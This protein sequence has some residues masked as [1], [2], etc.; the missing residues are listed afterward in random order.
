[1]TTLFQAIGGLG[2]FL[3]GMVIMTDALHALT[4]KAV[5]G[6]LMRFTRSPYS[7]AVTG[8]TATAVLQ[9]SSATTVAAVGFVGAGLISF[10]ES[11]GI[12]FGA[13]IGTTLKG[14]MVALLGFKFQLDIF[15]LPLIFVGALLRLFGHRQLRNGGMALAGFALI[16]VGIAAMQE[17]MSG[18]QD[19][20]TPYMFSADTVWGRLKLLLLGVLFTLLTQSSSAGVAVAL[21]AVYTGSINF[22]QAAALVIGM[23]VGTTVTAAMATIGG[24]VAARR[25]GFSHVIYNLLTGVMAFMLLTPFTLLLETAWPNFLQQQA[26]VALVAFHSS[27]NILGVL[28]ILPFTN[29]FTRMMQRLIPDQADTYTRSLDRK[30]LV[31]PDLAINAVQTAI[32]AEL[33]A[34]LKQLRAMLDR[35][36]ERTLVNLPALQ[37]A[38]N[39]THAYADQIHLDKAQQPGW[40]TLMAIFHSLDHL[41]RLHERCDEDMDRARAAMHTREL[42]DQVGLFADKLERM[43]DDIENNRWQE[44]QEDAAQIVEQFAAQADDLRNSIMSQLAEGNIDVDQSTSS[45]QA[46]RWLNRVSAHVQ[47]VIYHQARVQGMLISGSHQS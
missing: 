28:L 5:R 12:I 21:T 14:W 18:L 10:P 2:L 36:H 31:E 29:A 4:G 8:A 27:F 1:M 24:S 44:A 20:I 34:L 9:S 40:Q 38:L 41:Q 30:L 45:L 11:L 23:D 19:S 16:F 15:L 13:N 26:E 43:I 17:G 37:L 47:R 7:G 22:Q 6:A 42:V 3:L 33:L 32:H 25:T 39:E 35:G 46:I